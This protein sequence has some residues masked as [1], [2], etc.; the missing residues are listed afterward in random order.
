MVFE[1]G[2]GRNDQCHSANS[3]G[4][5]SRRTDEN[6]FHQKLKANLRRARA[7]RLPQSDLLL[8]L[9]NIRKH[10]VHDSRATHGQRDQSYG[11]QEKSHRERNVTCSFQQRRKIPDIVTGVPPMTSLKQSL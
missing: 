7:E 8:S 11:E 9:S 3:A 2:G 5:G 10:D 4:Q 1:E 6:C